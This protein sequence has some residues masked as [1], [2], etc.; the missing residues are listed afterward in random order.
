M[1]SDQ[2]IRPRSGQIKTNDGV[3][4]HYLEAGSGPPLVLV[5]GWSQ[6]AAMFRAQLDG[7]SSN[8]RVIALDMRGHGQSEKPEH[9]YRIARLAKDLHE[10]LVALNLREVNLAGHSMGCA[11]IWSY[12]DQFGDDRLRRLILID[13]P[14]TPLIWP[15]WTDTDRAHA[16][17]RLDATALMDFIAGLTGPEGIQISKD[18]I[19]RSFFTSAVLPVTVEWVINENLQFPRHFAARLLVDLYVQDWRDVLPRITLPTLVVGGEASLFNPQSQ[20][21]N[22]DQIPGAR[23]EMFSAED[24]GSHFMWLENPERFNA[25]IRDFISS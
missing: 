23:L 19:T 18:Y 2:A 6:T 9:G 8:C 4:L 21:W 16:G 22:A 5:P 24:G 17:S 20:R 25:L 12:W 13:Q 3:N 11:V 7:L 15:N 1:S 10:A 14:A